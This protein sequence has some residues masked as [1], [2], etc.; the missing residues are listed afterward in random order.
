MKIKKIISELDIELSKKE[1]LF[2]K[3]ET[4]E[5]CSFLKKN[6]KENKIK[7]DIFVGGSFAKRTLLKGEKYDIDIL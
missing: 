1:I 2:L 6:I 5:I 7:A 4:K 3:K